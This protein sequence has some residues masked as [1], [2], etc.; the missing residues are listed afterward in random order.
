[1]IRR[2]PR[3]TLFPYTTLFRSQIPDVPKN[4]VIDGATFH[5]FTVPAS[6]PSAHLDCVHTF[7][8]D[9]LTI[10]NSTFTRCQHFG[11]LVNGGRNITIENNFLSGGIYG[12]KLRGDNDPSIET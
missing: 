9:G 2:P 6:C 10:R 3:S 5:D 8:S 12:F 1:M 4:V 11:I 7:G